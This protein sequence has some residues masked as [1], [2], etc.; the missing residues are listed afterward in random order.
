MGTKAM[1]PLIIT[2]V[3]IAV[4]VMRELTNGISGKHILQLRFALNVISVP[5]LIYFLINFLIIWAT[6]ANTQAPGITTN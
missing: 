4:L 5:L 3:L 6:L 1:L 2:A